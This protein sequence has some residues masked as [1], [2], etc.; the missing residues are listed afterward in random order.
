MKLSRKNLEQE[1][2]IFSIAKPEDLPKIAQVCKAL[3]LP[4]RLQIVRQLQERPLSIPE[5]AKMNFISISAAVYHVEMLYNSGVVDV[6]YQTSAHGDVRTCYRLMNRLDIDLWINTP[7]AAEK[8]VEY[9]MGVGQFV[10]CEGCK[11]CSFVSNGKLF[12]T[13]WDNVFMRERF[14]A[15][16]FF[17]T[18]GFVTYAFPSNF[19]TLHK[20]IELNISLELCSEIFYYNN[21]WKSDVTFWINGVE[22]LTYT[23]PGDFG[24]RPGI[25]NPPWW[26]RNVT[27]YGEL[28]VITVTES[29]VFLDGQPISKTPKLSDLQLNASN[30]ILF[31][32]GNKPTAQ[33]IGGFN[34]FGKE[35]GDYPQDI[36]LTAKYID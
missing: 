12:H 11:D 2:A 1:K 17:A 23:C 10:E 34:L 16:L 8:T 6:I 25:L 28:K 32:L 35:F 5:I 15:Q 13:S 36:V 30:R 31:R 24:G 4:L 7:T 21:Y 20:C 27:Q 22:L 26:D 29:G 9:S 14:D 33:Y 18:E 3:S 19:A